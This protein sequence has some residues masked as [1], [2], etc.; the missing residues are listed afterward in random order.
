MLISN[1]PERMMLYIIN[2]VKKQFPYRK[3]IFTNWDE[4]DDA[5]LEIIAEDFIIL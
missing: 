3:F 5:S 2:E 4:R 1:R